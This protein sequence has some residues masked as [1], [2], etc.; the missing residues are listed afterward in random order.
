VLHGTN[1]STNA[2]HRDAMIEKKT[3]KWIFIVFLLSVMIGIGYL[4]AFSSVSRSGFVRSWLGEYSSQLISDSRSDDHFFI[5]LASAGVERTK[6][7]VRYDPAYVR[8]PYPNGDVPAGM[9][10]CTDEIV[11]AYRRVG[12]DLQA[13]V[14]EDMKEVFWSYPKLWRMTGPDPNIDHRRVPN[15]MVYLTRKGSVLPIDNDPLI[16]RPGDIVAW[17]LSNGLLHIG[18]VVV[19][20]SRDGKRHLIVHNI[21]QGP[22]LEDALFV[23]RIIG[24]FRYQP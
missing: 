20:R 9:G 2:L 14:H 10:V 12:I 19:P 11:R 1:V 21:G 16:Y 24:H 17:E 15:L 7:K 3:V 18:L 6:Y 13:G 5:R 4:S 22:K 8:I 23:G